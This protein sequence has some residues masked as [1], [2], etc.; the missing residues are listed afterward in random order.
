MSELLDIAPAVQEAK[1]Q[2]KPVVA[3][4][5]TIITHGMPYPENVETAL[6][7]ENIIRDIGA[8]PAT[9]ALVGGKI[10][11]GL[12]EAEITHLAE[13]GD[14]VKVSR[15][16][17]AWAASTRKNGATT[18]AGTM[19]VAARAGIKFFVTG[20]I[21]GVH[22]HGSQTFDISADITE[23]GRTPVTVIAAGAK[24]ILDLPLTYERL[25]TE[26][27]PVIA[28]R[29][30]ELPAFY[31]R[32]SGITAPLRVDTVRDLARLIAA[33]QS[34]E[35][36]TGILV[37]NPIPEAA[38]IPAQEINPEIEKAL[39]EAE[40]KNITGRELTPFLLDKIKTITEGRS[41]EANIALVKNNARLG[42]DIALAYQQ[43]L[44]SGYKL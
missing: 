39:Q 42:A 11:V 43:F 7:V 31:S 2:S 23:L 21:G 25:E 14:V 34:L 6:E 5:S 28:Y 32:Q 18:V 15:R 10:K 44:A 29:S 33:Q 30:D 1:Y 22:R 26:G 36:Q 19:A 40:D 12:T 8:V 3:L 27:V 37:A 41:L 20:G 35:L 24:A 13:A 16:D 38:E 4:E 17:L 9:I